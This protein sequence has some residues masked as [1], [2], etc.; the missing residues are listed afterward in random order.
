M[1]ARGTAGSPP[2]L[3]RAYDDPSPDA[4]N[5]LVLVKDFL[6]RDHPL[7]A[8]TLEMVMGRLGHGPLVY[9]YLAEDGLPGHEGAF[10]PCSFWLVEALAKVG[11][12]EEAVS[13]FEE[14]VA[15][16]SAL[17]LLP[18]EM[19][20]DTGEYLGNYPQ[21]LS[22]LALVNAAVALEE[23]SGARRE[24]PWRDR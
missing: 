13:R 22:H 15:R 19:D 20:P 23:A 6:P 3:A 21:G 9:R 1:L 4:S 14:L 8:G 10:L 11:R 5:L 7:V 16:A 18:E 24:R 17:G 12:Q 2:Y